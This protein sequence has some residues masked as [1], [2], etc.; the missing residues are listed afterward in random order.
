M[1]TC[2]YS[3]I[4]ETTATKQH[5]VCT[6]TVSRHWIHISRGQNPTRKHDWYSLHVLFQFHFLFCSLLHCSVFFLWHRIFTIQ[7]ISSYF[8]LGW[9]PQKSAFLDNWSR[10]LQARCPSCHPTNSVKALNGT[11]HKFTNRLITM[12]QAEKCHNH[13]RISTDFN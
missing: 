12:H 13:C 9:V 8:G 5:K 6:R 11:F 4:K 1:L 3:V 7:F 10:F 2:I